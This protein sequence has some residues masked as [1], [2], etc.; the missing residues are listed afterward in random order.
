[1][2]FSLVRYFGRELN[3]THASAANIFLEIIF[4]SFG[5]ILS[6]FVLRKE[7]VSYGAW[8][9]VSVLFPLTNGVLVSQGRYTLVLFPIFLTLAR[10]VRKNFL[11]H[12]IYLLISLLLLGFLTVLFI[13]GYWSF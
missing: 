12:N 10:V 7:R 1:M 11:L 5:L 8:C 3:F 6:I 9:L 2:A 13:N 4:F